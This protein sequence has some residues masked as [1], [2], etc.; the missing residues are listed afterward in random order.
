MPRDLL[1]NRE[2]ID[3][4]ANNNALGSARNAE[5]VLLALSLGN[6]IENMHAHAKQ[7]GNR[8]GMSGVVTDIAKGAYNAVPAAGEFLYDLPGN[9]L[10]SGKLAYEDPGLA[11]RYAKAGLASGVGGLLNIPKNSV[12]YLRKQGL[13]PESLSAFNPEQHGLLPKDFD[14]LAAEGLTEPNK[15]GEFIY[16]ASQFAPSGV[17]GPLAPAAWAVGQNENP[18]TAQLMPK[19]SHKIA[20]PVA[21]TAIKT[22][23]HLK[24]A[25]L[26]PSNYFASFSKNNISLSELADNMRAAEGTNTGLGDVIKSPKY[27]R[28]L[29][30]DLAQKEPYGVEQ[31]YKKINDQ[32][33]AKA[34]T[35]LFDEI[36]KGLP[37]QDTNPVVKE[38]L[39]KAYEDN[40]TVKNNLYNKA[41]EIAD[42]ENFEPDLTKFQNLVSANAATIADSPLLKTNAEFAGEFNKLTKINKAIT[43]QGQ[44]LGSGAFV[45]PKKA[46]RISLKEANIIANDLYDM[47][48]QMTKSPN[49]IDRAHGGLYKKLG[50]TLRED[51]NHSIETKGSPELKKAA[52]EAKTYYKD[53]FVQFL[54]KDLYKLLDETKNPDAIV[55]GIIKPSTRHDNAALI[56]KVQAV[57]P[58]DQKGL[59]GYTYLRGALQKSAETGKYELKPS[60]I[61]ALVN[62]LGTKQ[63]EALFPDPKI[64]GAILDFT[65][66]HNMNSEAASYLV[67]P[68]TGAR[69]QGFLKQMVEYVPEMIAGGGGAASGGAVGAILGLTAAK[70]LKTASNKYMLEL[71]TSEEFRNKVGEKIKKRKM[72]NSKD[73][74]IP[75][76]KFAASVNE[77]EERK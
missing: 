62:S 23:K 6:E 9:L 70:L 71:L 14:F 38:V 2:P 39:R 16:G 64:R 77:K 55:Q 44:M 24:S 10:E 65:K 35:L 30:N 48:Q 21:T 75:E 67:N 51:V 69:N 49:A 32:I 22:L 56:K 3:L 53:E 42:I 72:Q 29:E 54:E 26:T 11:K 36:G 19:V 45:V 34:D 31:T 41:S 7:I 47:G 1:A 46:P 43:S 20:K 57:L 66:L 27:K 50:M 28:Q 17:F 37:D 25:D 58:A 12:D 8:K 63:F 74:N 61:K 13:A 59:L 33:Q 76:P 68:K 60:A 40:R 15:G 73:A 18:V 5:D 4:L 52:N